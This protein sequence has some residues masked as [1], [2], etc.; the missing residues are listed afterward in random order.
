[1][2]LKALPNDPV[3]VLAG[4]WLIEF[5]SAMTTAGPSAAFNARL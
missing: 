1:M 4:P 3:I 2:N 5:D